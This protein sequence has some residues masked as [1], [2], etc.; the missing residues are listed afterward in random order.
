MRLAIAAFLAAAGVALAADPAPDPFVHLEN[1]A[2][3]RT[4][5]FVREQGRRA[6]EALDRIPGRGELLARIRALTAAGGPVVSHV[7]LGGA[8]VFYLRS[9]AG[10][11]GATLLVREGMSGAERLLIDA[12]R[13]AGTGAAIHWIAP[14]P[15]GRHVAL[16]IGPSEREAVLRVIAVDGARFMPVQ[17]T[18]VRFNHGLA[19]HPDG[20]AF[21]YAREIEGA[22]PA[23]RGANMRVYRHVLGRAAERDEVVFAPGVGG[24]RDVPEFAY[25]SLHIPAESRYA[26]AIVRDGLR[27]HIAVHVTQQ[28]ELAAG[29]PAWRKIVA[30]EDEVLAVEGWRDELYLLSHKNTPRNRVLRMKAGAG[31]ATARPIVPQGDAVIEQMGLARDALYL[32]TMVGGVD[33]LER[34]P[35]GLLGA[36]APEF[37]RL[38]FDQ[39]IAQLV[40]HPRQPGALV[41]LQGWIEAPLVAQLEPRSGE[42]R[43]TPIQPAGAADFSA[44]DEVRLYAPAADGAK[45]PVTLVYPKS[46]RLTGENALLLQVFGS[47][48]RTVS[49]VFDPARLAW[50]ERGGVI[51]FAHVR[52]GGEYGEAWHQAA[53]GGT[54]QVSVTDMIAV[55]EF[56][57]AYGFTNPRRI[58]LAGEGA[59]GIVLGGAVARRPDLFAALVARWPLADLVRHEHGVD[60]RAMG[61]ELPREPDA[62]RALSPYHQ[63]KEGV[64]YPAALLDM[65]EAGEV[66]A[67]HAAKMA[68]RLQQA[69]SRPALLRTTPPQRDEWLADRFAFA[70]S[71]MG[72]PGFVVRPPEPQP[73]AVAAPP[74]RGDD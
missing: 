53:R 72:E 19:W 1:P 2:D 29:R 33:R 11:A 70:W 12:A 32:R 14:A 31:I 42:L 3:A 15:D 27:R 43:R 45:I 4:Q 69:G 38:P 21:Y 51:A 60:G 64:A 49:P 26:Y 58:A 35:I 65:S 59:A 46:T 36:K 44:M 10:V 47:F 39:A 25:P 50:L 6:R 30:H 54:K 56:L 41:R 18:R 9:Q 8:R 66:D 37:I 48:G 73:P 74:E 7:A 61:A 63:L 20:R 28:S 55:A 34:V 57:V 62:L 5:E 16:A 13:E 40:T 17:I 52:G 68:A 23:R 22:E 24:A 71:Q 67:W